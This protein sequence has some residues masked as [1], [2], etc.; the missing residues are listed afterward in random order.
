MLPLSGN[1]AISDS[2]PSIYFARL[3]E[4]LKEDFI[5]I[6]DSHYINVEALQAAFEDDYDEF[7]NYRKE[8]LKEAILSL[9]ENDEGHG[10]SVL[11]DSDPEE[12]LDDAYG[13]YNDEAYSDL[14]EEAF[15]TTLKFE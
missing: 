6:L 11:I 7:I 14:E 5:P 2:K 15:Q 13:E 12:D 10:N 4:S 1:R 3:E 9:T 8:V